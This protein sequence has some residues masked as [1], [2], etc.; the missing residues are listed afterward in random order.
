MDATALRGQD[1]RLFVLLA[2]SQVE[3]EREDPVH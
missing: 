1:R 3:V 2:G